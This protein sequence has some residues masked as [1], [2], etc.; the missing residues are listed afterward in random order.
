MLRVAHVEHRG[1]V[2]HQAGIC[3]IDIVLSNLRQVVSASSFNERLLTFS[4]DLVVLDI[5][6]IVE[7][8]C[9]GRGLHV[10]L[11]VE[12][13]SEG[14]VHEGVEDLHE[15]QGEHEDAA[16]VVEHHLVVQVLAD[17][18]RLE[19]EQ[20]VDGG[21]KVKAVADVFEEDPSVST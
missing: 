3:L 11:E 15:K 7:G 21:E 1:G 16:E 9:V 4:L 14:T 8:D 13:G 12:D 18:H 5:E 19:V 6:S 20:G 10:V 17:A 2:F